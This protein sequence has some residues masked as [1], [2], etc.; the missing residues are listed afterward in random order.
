MPLDGS[1][2]DMDNYVSITPL[3]YSKAVQPLQVLFPLLV[4]VLYAVMSYFA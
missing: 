1:R 2:V 3:F 4:G